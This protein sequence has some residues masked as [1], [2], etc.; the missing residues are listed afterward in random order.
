M[1]EYELADISKRMIL[2]NREFPY[3][4]ESGAEAMS[5]FC[6]FKLVYAIRPGC[7]L[8]EGRKGSLQFGSR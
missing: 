8:V 5:A 2:T 6:S 3:F 7:N 4:L 1:A